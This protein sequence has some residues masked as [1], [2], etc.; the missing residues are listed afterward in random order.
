MVSTE[1]LCQQV[2]TFPLDLGFGLCFILVGRVLQIH[3][4]KVSI[5]LSLTPVG[6]C[7]ARAK[8]FVN[9]CNITF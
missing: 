7:G 8:D 4:E 3:Q 2:T 9:V 1:Y 5:A 6:I